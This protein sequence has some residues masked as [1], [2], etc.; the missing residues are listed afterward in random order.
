MRLTEATWQCGH[1]NSPRWG[2][3]RS[4]WTH[5]AC[6]HRWHDTHWTGWRSR[7]F[8]PEWKR[9]APHTHSN[10]AWRDA[11]CS[12]NIFL[13]TVLSWI[14]W[15]HSVPSIFS[16]SST[17][18]R[19]EMLV[20]SVLVSILVSACWVSTLFRSTSN[21]MYTTVSSESEQL[22]SWKVDLFFLRFFFFSLVLTSKIK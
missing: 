22:S 6:C 15:W 9:F 14:S 18:A 20:F 16:L 17:A 8:L 7:N 5:S 19:F 1:L 12:V 4:Y 10:L 11:G 21:S 3:V 2:S 13:C